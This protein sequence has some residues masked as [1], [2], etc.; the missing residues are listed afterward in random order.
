MQAMPL[1]AH[2]GGVIDIDLCGPCHMVWFDRTESMRL[3]G[4][5]LLDLLGRM[6]GLQGA[7]HQ[8]LNPQPS[9]P[10]CSAVL[11]A[12]NNRSKY[13]R[14][15]QHDCPQDHGTAQTFSQFLAEKGY[16]RPIE[17]ADLSSLQSRHGDLN[18]INCGA[19]VLA[20]QSGVLP[21][22]CSYCQTPV[23]MIDVARLAQAIDRHGAGGAKAVHAITAGRLSLPCTHCG[24][25]VEPTRDTRCR[26]CAGAVVITSLLQANAL[27]QELRPGVQSRHSRRDP[28]LPS[29]PVE[30]S[31][32]ATDASAWQVEAKPRT[33]LREFNR[34]AEVVVAVGGLA[35]CIYLW[36]GLKPAVAVGACGTGVALVWWF[37]KLR[38]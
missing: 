33:A 7:V 18:C 30:R 26:Q 22:A 36:F 35:V 31:N 27:L 17:H 21:A 5:G 25:P 29:Q 24:A 16:V 38:G 28:L 10:D 6:A 8:P 13:G 34:F 37:N 1:A 32:L 9:C 12:V 23:N 19:S 11:S 4:T 20:G 3:S 14:S 2:Y 15:V